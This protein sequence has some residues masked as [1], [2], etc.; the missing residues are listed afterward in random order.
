MRIASRRSSVR[1]AGPSWCGSA[2]AV[3]KGHLGHLKVKA[4]VCVG[5]DFQQFLE[6]G[7]LKGCA[8]P[9]GGEMAAGL[10]AGLAGT[11]VSAS[12]TGSGLA[13]VDLDLVEYET[14]TKDEDEAKLETEDPDLLAR[15]ILAKAISSGASFLHLEP[16]GNE[17]VVA[18]RL[19]GILRVDRRLSGQLA[20]LL[21]SAYRE[22]AGLDFPPYGIPPTGRMQVSRDGARF[23][24]SLSILPI[25]DGDRL[26]MKI[27]KQVGVACR[28]AELLLD[29]GLLSVV[30]QMLNSSSGMVLFAGPAGSGRSTTVYSA[31]GDQLSPEV[32][33]VC[34]DNQA[35]YVLGHVARVNVQ[36][37]AAADHA[38]LIQAAL[39][40]D[41][42]ILVTGQITDAKSAGAA[43]EAAY[44]GFR[45]ISEIAAN[46]C[47]SALTRLAAMTAGLS[48]AA[49]ALEGLVSQRLVRRVC[50]ECS[51]EYAPPGQVMQSLGL[52]EGDSS[53]SGA[54]IREY[55]RSLVNQGEAVV[56][57]R[58]KGCQSCNDTGYQGRVGVFEAVRIT[59][60]I[61]ELIASNPHPGSAFRKAGIAS[62]RDNGL[63]LAAYGLTTPEEILRVA[64]PENG[65]VS[66]AHKD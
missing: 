58:G 35:S 18:F 34:V 30:R 47:A 42:D 38:S 10:P 51:Q 25:G 31:L 15:E 55:L 26:V 33:I 2:L 60:E 46:D 53:R 56:F 37:E 9:S 5:D 40:Q 61:R 32:S 24:V 28:L 11:S 64:P 27:V 41:P 54:A 45:V 36:G 52:S 23:D 21:D 29:S 43:L 48:A 4:V 12:C 6:T 8:Q 16:A 39:R 19:D 20:P 44:A 63:R 65:S 3:V 62:L 49:N 66:A 7:Y 17:L 13:V 59:H 57:R 14:G 1:S 22:M 50:P